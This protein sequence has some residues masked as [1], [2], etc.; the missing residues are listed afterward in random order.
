MADDI[1]LY[2]AT[3]TGPSGFGEAGR[4][5]VW[6][7]LEQDGISIC[8]RTHDH[9]F[10]RT[11]AQSGRHFPD[12]RFREY[13]LRNDLVNEAALIDDPR[14]AAKR[15]TNGLLEALNAEVDEELLIRQW[16]GEPADADVWLAVGGPGFAQHAPDGPYT[17][18]STDYNVDIVPGDVVERGA[19]DDLADLFG[20]PLSAT[21]DAFLRDE[22][23]IENR[24]QLE[25]WLEHADRADIEQYFQ[26]ETDGV[27]DRIAQIVDGC[28]VESVWKKNLPLVDE[29]WIPSEWTRQ[30]ILGR[31]PGLADDVHALP[32]GVSMRYE[33]GLYDHE[34]CPGQ[35][36]AVPH[37]G[38]NAHQQ[39]CLA[40]DSF[41]FLVISRFYHIKGLY[42]TI[43]AFMEAFTADEPVRLFVKTTSNQQFQFDA[44]ASVN[45]IR[46][47]LE[48]PNPPEVGLGSAPMDCQHL[49]DLMGLADC[50]VQASRAE[51]YGIAQ[52]QA[53]YCRT[54]VIYTDWSAQGELIDS[55]NAG[56]YPLTDYTVERPEPE[57]DYLMFQGPDRYP[58]DGK[59]ATPDVDSL[60]DLMRE[61]YELDAD[62]RQ[63][64]GHAARKFVE[65]TYQWADRIQPRVERLRAAAG[66]VVATGSKPTVSIG[67]DGGG[68]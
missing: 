37:S 7:F 42:R 40:D 12:T 8:C 56:F 49:A 66:H 9:G 64:A 13:L 35:N 29:V 67:A 16:D 11:G 55:D 48:Y 3:D 51:C 28:I 47:E 15:D 31:F 2:I 1:K 45:Q 5:L 43:R 34:N 18:L 59:W 58:T 33:P 21:D 52:F 50:F 27:K 57:V 17:I 68:E 54:P 6:E 63:A 39:P 60:A 30:A 46:Q 20:S 38:A 22:L 10:S 61:V 23:G 4:N 19:L 24:K 25:Q 53:A 65:D 62:E 32:Y 36:E 44:A 14:E 41:T 26:H